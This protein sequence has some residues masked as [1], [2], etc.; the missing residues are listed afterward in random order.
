[1]F[2]LSTSLLSFLPYF[3]LPILLHADKLPLCSDN[4]N[5][6]F[7]N[8]TES[9][10]VTCVK[11]VKTIVTNTS[12]WINPADNQSYPYLAL[13]LTNQM[14]IELNF[15]FPQS[16]LTYLDLAN[17]D[18]Y[19]I[20]D[21]VFQNL[22]SM[23]VLILSYN[24]LELLSPDAFKVMLLNAVETCKLHVFFFQGK[25]LAERLYPLKSLIEL[26]LD[27]NKL[28]TLNMNIFEHTTDLEILDLSYNPLKVIDK[29]TTIAIDNLP[30]LKVSKHS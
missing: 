23:R 4:C 7:I 14:F 9:A 19:G 30:M 8:N 11:D 12:S 18:I 25:Y 6:L 29:H 13:T 10:K 26:R 20:R 3:I 24:D 21:N 15:T 27:H 22:Q 1:M 5:C 17:N 28:H 16:G 2:R